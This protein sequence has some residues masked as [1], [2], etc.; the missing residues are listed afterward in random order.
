MDRIDLWISDKKKPELKDT[1]KGQVLEIQCLQQT[2][3]YDAWIGG[4]RQGEAPARYLYVT[5]SFWGS[6]PQ[7]H[8]QKIY[9]KAIALKEAKDPRQHMHVIGKWGKSREYNGK[10]YADFRAYEASPLLFG[11][12]Q[13][14]KSG[15]ES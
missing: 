5:V 7:S 12:L 1:P 13:Q 9:E 6:E 3:A 2:D 4:G 10:Q 11:P 15:D 8:A 14:R